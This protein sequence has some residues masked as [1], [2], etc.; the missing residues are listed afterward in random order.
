MS[1]Y[2]VLLN[3][4]G[5][6]KEDHQECMDFFTD[7]YENARKDF[8]RREMMKMVASQ[9]ELGTLGKVESVLKKTNEALKEKVKQKMA[10][11]HNNKFMFFTINPKPSVKLEDFLRVVAKSVLK[12]CFTEFMYVIEQRGTNSETAGQGFHA[13]I[14]VKR[15]VKYKPFKCKQN[16]QNTY[17]KMC[18]VKNDALFNVKYLNT[19]WAIDKVNYITTG[20]KTGDGKD[21]KQDIDVWWR[22]IKNIQP[23]YGNKEITLN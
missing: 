13:H 14:L 4:E 16:M 18:D 6:F 8:L 23:Y 7:L 15:N 5:F 1:I 11:D 22:D 9:Y 12:T 3:T 21:V 19:E 10:E 2:S 17:S 20:G